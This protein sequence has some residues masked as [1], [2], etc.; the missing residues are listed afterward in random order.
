MVLFPI[1]CYTCNKVVGS[2]YKKYKELTADYGEKVAL[3]TLG[4]KRYCCRRMFLTHVDVIDKIIAYK[5][6][7]LVQRTSDV[8]VETSTASVDSL[9][10][11]M[12]EIGLSSPIVI[13]EIDDDGMVVSSEKYAKVGWNYPK[14]L[15]TSIEVPR[16]FLC[17]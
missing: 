7:L 15:D 14:D 11:D 2:L 4:V 3:D 9:T 16:I 5:N 10:D 8:D 13:D 12:R 1:R 6:P 17:R